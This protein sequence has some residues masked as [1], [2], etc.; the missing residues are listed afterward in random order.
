M[1]K[2]VKK[3]VDRL[4]AHS[5]EE[6]KDL[7]DE[8]LQNTLDRYDE[9]IAAGRSER[10]A[11]D[12]AIAGIGNIRPLFYEERPMTARRTVELIVT[13]ILWISATIGFVAL[14][15]FG[16]WTYAWLL[17][18]L[19]GTLNTIFKGLVR[20]LPRGEGIRLL[21]HGLLWL[22]VIYVYWHVSNLTGAWIVTWLIFPIGAAVNAFADGIVTLAKGGR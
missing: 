13:L 2:A 7:H 10:E 6:N 22:A 4:F 8:I 21:V 19:A 14:C 12:A 9:E 18:P 1:R 17:F 5:A 3:Y 16:Y 20:L 11:Y 15:Y